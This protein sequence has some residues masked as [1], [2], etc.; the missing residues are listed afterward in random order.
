MFKIWSKKIESPNSFAMSKTRSKRHTSSTQPRVTLDQIFNSKH[1][2]SSFTSYSMITRPINSIVTA[3]FPLFSYSPKN[4]LLI[5]RVSHLIHPEGS[6]K[7]PSHFAN[8]PYVNSSPKDGLGKLY[9]G[10]C[11]VLQLFCNVVSKCPCYRAVWRDSEHLSLGHRLLLVFV[12]I[13][14]NLGILRPRYRIWS[15]RCPKLRNF[16]LGGPWNRI[17]RRRSGRMRTRVPRLVLCLHQQ[18]SRMWCLLQWIHR[19]WPLKYWATSCENFRREFVV[20][21]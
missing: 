16:C 6:T 13:C 2:C 17:S 19:H 3:P 14:Y 8:K 21:N 1:I 7:S 9:M 4:I 12:R 18:C 10:Q 20:L 15:R 11:V 5:L